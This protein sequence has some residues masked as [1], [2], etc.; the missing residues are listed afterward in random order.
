MSKAYRGT[1]LIRNRL[2]LGPCSSPVPRGLGWSWG[3]SRFLLGEV[4]LYAIGPLGRAFKE[5]PKFF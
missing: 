5:P 3:G 2:L 4:A 1:L